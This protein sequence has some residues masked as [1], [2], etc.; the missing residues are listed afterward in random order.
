M[1]DE[2]DK[3]LQFVI[4]LAWVWEKIIIVLSRDAKRIIKFLVRVG[5][6]LIRIIPSSGIGFSYEV[7]PWKQS[8]GPTDYL[9][10]IEWHLHRD[11]EIV[12]IN[13]F[14]MLV[15]MELVAFQKIWIKKNKHFDNWPQFNHLHGCQM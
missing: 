15:R 6:K 9:N 3:N 10:K 5:L 7:R 8:L 4:V 11:S 14:H 12:S 13:S 1:V 2:Y